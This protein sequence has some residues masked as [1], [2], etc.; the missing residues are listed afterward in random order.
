MQRI[1]V[2]SLDMPKDRVTHVV[3]FAILADARSMQRNADYVFLDVSR[4]PR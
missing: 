4:S 3:V 2:P 1:S